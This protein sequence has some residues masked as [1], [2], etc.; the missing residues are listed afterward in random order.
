MVSSKEGRIYVVMGSESKG[1]QPA[2]AEA[3]SSPL[4]WASINKIDVLVNQV[5]GGGA[6]WSAM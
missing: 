5:L 4:I 6:K 2:L 3:A 1:A